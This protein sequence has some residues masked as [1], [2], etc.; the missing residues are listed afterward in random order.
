MALK[1]RE[2]HLVPLNGE[3]D[4]LAVL[5]EAVR[6]AGDSREQML[7][8]LRAA[9]VLFDNV[10]VLL[11]TVTVEAYEATPA[12]TRDIAAARGK[13]VDRGDPMAGG[14]IQRKLEGLRGGK[15]AD[16]R[17]REGLSERLGA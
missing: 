17:R 15:L 7:T 14:N 13:D 12:S 3:I 9:R 6:P 8:A 5:L 11:D 16:R 2:A 1:L 10:G 4:R